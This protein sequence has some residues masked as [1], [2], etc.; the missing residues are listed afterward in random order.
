VEGVQRQ[1]DIFEA[2]MLYRMK[3]ALSFRPI[4]GEQS[5]LNELVQEIILLGRQSGELKKDL[6]DDLLAGLFEYCLIS[7]V[8]PFYL[9]PQTYNAAK[10][11]NLGVDLF[12]NGAGEKNP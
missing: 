10:S 8:K 9:D 7:A 12:L 3:Q 11:V 2:F 1:K 5:G 4:E 6:P